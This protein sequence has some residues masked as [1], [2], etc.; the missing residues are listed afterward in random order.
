M[1][2]WVTNPE[3]ERNGSGI[4]NKAQKCTKSLEYAHT[5]DPAISPLGTYPPKIAEKV[6]QEVF[7]RQHCLHF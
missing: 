1:L 4:K 7:I 5:S 3:H 2:K 6:G